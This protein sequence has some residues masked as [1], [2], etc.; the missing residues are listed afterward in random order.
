[1]EVLSRLTGGNAIA[2]AVLALSIISVVGLALAAIKFR[3]VGLGVTGVLFAGLFFGHIGWKIEEEVLHFVREFGLILFVFTI[4]LQI[5]PGF[6]ASLRRQGLPANICAAAVVIGGALLT[7]FL[8]WIAGIHPFAAAGLFSGATTNTPSLGAAQ[9]ALAMV[10]GTDPATRALLALAYAVAYPGGVL[11]IILCIVLLRVLFR[12]D[13]ATELEAFEIERRSHAPVLKRRNLLITNS[14]LDGLAIGKIPGLRETGIILSRVQSAGSDEVRVASQET[15]I[16]VGD[17]VLAVGSDDALDSFQRIVGGLSERNLL[18]T[19][20]SIQQRRIIV[21]HKSPLGKSLRQLAIHTAYG[22]VVTRIQRGEFEM[23]ADPDMRLQFGD[24]LHVVGDAQGLDQAAALLGNA[25]KE[26]AHTN[27]LPVFLGVALGVAAGLVPIAV[28]GLPVPVRLG[29]AGGPLV[30]AILLS[31]LGRIGPIVFYM[32]PNANLA[33]RELG[34]VLFL[35]CVGLKAG[36]RFVPT[37]LSPDGLTWLAAGFCV[38]LVPILLVGIIARLTLR[39]NYTALSGIVAGSMTD[40]P[41]L[42][43]SHAMLKS[44]A[45]SI[46]YASVY[47]LTMLLRILCAQVLILI[48][49]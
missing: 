19:N 44:D 46:S 36:E 2:E 39:M 40:P 21:T 35:A 7:V 49:S 32:P 48:F 47:P 37:L 18:E 16:R 33:L 22:V 29:L 42:A 12:I 41:A 23:A 27:F 8:A 45:P 25:P 43:F 17:T 20:S 28:P 13:P 31:R 4:G 14:N 11:G 5:G 1:M 26:L 15:V 6:F 9:Q 10:P 3:G 38:T 24:T 34:I 30:V